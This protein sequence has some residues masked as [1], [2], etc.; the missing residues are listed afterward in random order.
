MK[1]CKRIN[2]TVALNKFFII[3]IINRAKS[4]EPFH[5][6]RIRHSNSTTGLRIVEQAAVQT[7]N[8][9]NPKKTLTTFV[10]IAP[11]RVPD[12]NQIDKTED[13]LD[14]NPHL[15]TENS[16]PGQ[17]TTETE[18]ENSYDATLMCKSPQV[19]RKQAIV[20]LS[21]INDQEEIKDLEQSFV[22]LDEEFDDL[23]E[24]SGL[25]NESLTDLGERSLIDASTRKKLIEDVENLLMRSDLR[26]PK[27]IRTTEHRL[28]KKYLRRRNGASSLGPGSVSSSTSFLF[29]EVIIE[30]DEEALEAE[31]LEIISSRPGILT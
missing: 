30:E 18:S 10:P 22:D 4:P 12:T 26:K 5:H 19:T 1:I 13:N 7:L 16:K 2:Q 8:N 14:E 15:D 20:H 23:E 27:K 25:I 11:I 9:G 6:M 31:N 17:I 3:L 28:R 29:D 24:N 21:N